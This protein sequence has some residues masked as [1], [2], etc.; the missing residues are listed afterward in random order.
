MNPIGMSI[1]LPV[2][3]NPMLGQI[4]M[5]PLHVLGIFL[6]FGFVTACCVIAWK[7]RHTSSGQARIE[8]NPAAVQRHDFDQAA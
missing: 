2:N 6:V 1:P 5:E 3:L 8:P 4:G 7:T